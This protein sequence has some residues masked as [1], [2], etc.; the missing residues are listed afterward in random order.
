VSDFTVEKLGSEDVNFGTGTFSRTSRVTPGSTVSISQVNADDVPILDGGGIFDA[1]TVDGAIDE[2][3]KQGETSLR[4]PGAASDASATTRIAVFHARRAVTISNAYFIPD[5]DFDQS[6]TNY[7]SMSLINEDTDG[8]GTTVLV[9]KSY[10]GDGTTSSASIPI[11][12]GTI[13]NAAVAD[14]EVLSLEIDSTKGGTGTAFFPPGV[15]VVE[16]TW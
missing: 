11:S 13:A 1:T 2:I 4:F 3:G 10:N 15:I 12:L 16:Y 9:E 8:T 5:W 7:S 6:I 14:G